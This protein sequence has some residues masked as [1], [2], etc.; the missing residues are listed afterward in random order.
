MRVLIEIV[1]PAD[2]LFFLRPA[3]AFLGRGDEVLFVSRNKDVACHLLDGF[4]FDHTPLSKAERGTFGLASELLGRDWALYKY[5]RQTRP[6]VM[7]GFGG[8]AISHVAKLTGIP[9][10]VFYDSDNATLQNRLTWPFATSITV[11]DSFASDPPPEK[12][13]RF[14]GIKE[15]S[16]FHPDAFTASRKRA[17]LQGLDPYRPNIFIRLVEWRANHDLG[18]SGWLTELASELVDAFAATHKLHVSAEKDAPEILSKYRWMG[19]PTEIHHL[20]GHCDAMIG[21]SATMACEAVTLGTPALYA[22]VDFPGYTRE[23]ECLG[24]MTLLQP[25]QRSDLIAQ[26]HALLTNHAAFQTQRAAWL[27]TVP[28]W[29]QIVVNEASRLVGATSNVRPRWP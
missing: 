5:V 1:H 29:S 9:A 24:L 21:E 3:K 8:V 10:A 19:N 6:D 20:I 17:L 4:G 22:G 13:F 28:D 16:C 14:P 12:T 25:D 18:K 15:L 11:P 2:V 23:L 26:T 7:L 27:K